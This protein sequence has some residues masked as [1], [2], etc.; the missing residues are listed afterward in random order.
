MNT[1]S[2]PISFYI[3]EV[4]AVANKE[5]YTLKDQQFGQLTGTDSFYHIYDISCK[6]VTPNPFSPIIDNIK[7]AD[8]NTKKI[9]LIGEQVLI[10][11]GYQETS[12]PDELKP[13]WY[14]L[15]TVSIT[16]NINYNG[17][18]GLTQNNLTGSA[19]G[20][21]F[22]E[23]IVP[24]LQVYEGDVISEGRWGNSIRFS[25][26]IDT[27]KAQVEIQ[28]LYKG[29]TPG[30]PLILLSNRKR[31]DDIFVTENIQEDESSLYLT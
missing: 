24:M 7:P 28:P 27:K 17:I 23:Q 5:T 14:Y 10:F 16:S 29:T 31:S 6:I 4:V 12:K 8:I 15:T 2:N 1:Y 30:D 11:Q 26:T 20:T 22:E 21:S 18:T 13:A 19:A 9:P 25:S 3:A